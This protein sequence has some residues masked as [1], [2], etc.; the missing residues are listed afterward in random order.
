MLCLIN[1]LLDINWKEFQVL[2]IK[3]E[4][5]MYVKFACRFDDKNDDDGF[6][7]LFYFHKVVKS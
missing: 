5:M 3:L 1:V 2:C 4:L 6:S 7:S